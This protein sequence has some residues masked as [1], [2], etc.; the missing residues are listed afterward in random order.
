MVLSKNCERL[1]SLL[2]DLV[3]GFFVTAD[4]V[5]VTLNLL[6][7]EADLLVDVGLEVRELL[8]LLWKYKYLNGISG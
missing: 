3:D 8:L 2:F 6:L 1:S 7:V 4:G 5:F